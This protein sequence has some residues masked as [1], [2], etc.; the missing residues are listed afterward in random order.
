ML[1]L[2]I[3]SILVNQSGPTT[4]IRVGSKCNHRFGGDLIM[5]SATERDITTRHVGD[6]AD[7]TKT[8]A[9]AA[10]RVRD[11]GALLGCNANKLIAD[12]C[13]GSSSE[14]YKVAAA[15][16]ANTTSY[17]ASNRVIVS[18]NGDRRGRVPAVVDD[19]LNGVACISCCDRGRRRRT[20]HW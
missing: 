10:P 20:N 13:A 12:G 5:G 14:A 9:L 15:G 16:L 2:S 4:R 7:T 19:K 11:G 3:C 1:Q 6:D 8:S 18:V 17:S